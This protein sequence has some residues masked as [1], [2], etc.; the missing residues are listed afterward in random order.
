MYVQCV[1]CTAF[2]FSLIWHPSG[3]RST[4]AVLADSNIVLYDLESS[5]SSA[6]VNEFCFFYF[7]LIWLLLQH[8]KLGRSDSV[9]ES[10]NECTE[11]LTMVQLIKLK[12]LKRFI[13]RKS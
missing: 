2:A 5:G 11:L 8:P 6:R 10:C 3:E 4:F 12:I 1:Y 13:D 7:H 9:T